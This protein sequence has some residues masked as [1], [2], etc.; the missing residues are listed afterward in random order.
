MCPVL[1]LW[2]GRGELGEWYDV[3]TIWRDWANDVRGRPLN[4]G[5]HLAEEAPDETYAELHTFFTA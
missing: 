3:P 4:A 2:G 5:H 1:V